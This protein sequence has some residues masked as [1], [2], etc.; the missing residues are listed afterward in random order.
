M[1]SGGFFFTTL[2]LD[3]TAANS[4]STSSGSQE[5]IWQGEGWTA[6]GFHP[7]L[8]EAPQQPAGMGSREQPLSSPGRQ[9][10]PL[11]W[12]GDDRAHITERLKDLSKWPGCSSTYPGV[13]GVST[14][15]SLIPPAPLGRTLSLGLRA[16]TQ[17]LP[18]AEG[19]RCR[20]EKCSLPVTGE[21]EPAGLCRVLWVLAGQARGH[22]GCQVFHVGSQGVGVLASE[23]LSLGT[24]VAAPMRH[25][26]TA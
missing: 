18:H 6:W 9:L 14:C 12:D 11:T 10:A 23:V 3:N 21:R 19:L 5:E 22:P 1:I 8:R 24:V 26:D 7:A 2:P 4:R 13:K 15:I 16:G 17:P 20:G 25:G